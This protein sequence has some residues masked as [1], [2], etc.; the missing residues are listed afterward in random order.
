MTLNLVQAAY[1]VAAVL[2]VLSLAGLSKHESAKEG[3]AFGVTGMG[4][5]NWS[6]AT[7]PSAPSGAGVLTQSGSGD[8]PWAVRRDANLADGY[9]EARFRTMPGRQE[10]AGSVIWR[11]KNARSYYAARADARR[12]R[13]VLAYAVGGAWTEVKSVDVTVTPDAWHLLRAE[14]RGNLMRVLL[15]GNPVLEA[16]DDRIRGPGGVGIGTHGD[17]MT[18]FDDVRYGR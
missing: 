9:V 12:G 15:D 11:W 17:A 18:G 8:F 5:A 1:I 10:Q 6:I 13:V 3:N 2:F 16:R 14:F 7:D 4:L